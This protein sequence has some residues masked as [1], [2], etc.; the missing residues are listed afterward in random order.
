MYRDIFKKRRKIKYLGLVKFV[1]VISIVKLK[2]IS[3]K[4][5]NLPIVVGFPAQA[6]H[7]WNQYRTCKI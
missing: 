7:F 2:M 3:Y 6:Q 1:R 5:E 4:E